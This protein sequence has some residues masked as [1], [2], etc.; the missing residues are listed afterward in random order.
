MVEIR[1]EDFQGDGYDWDIV[2][3]AGNEVMAL[4]ADLAFHNCNPGEG[5]D[6]FAKYDDVPALISEVRGHVERLDEAIKKAK[7]DIASVERAARLAAVRR[8]KREAAGG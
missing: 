1:R 5:W 4:V 3:Q 7:A 8:E 2:V 6:P